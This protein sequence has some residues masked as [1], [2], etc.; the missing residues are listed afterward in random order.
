MLSE[1]TT[2]FAGAARSAGGTPSA[3][4]ALSSRAP[5]MC[6]RQSWRFAAAA[7][8]AVSSTESVVPPARVWVFSRMSRAARLSATTSSTAAGSM[9]P[10]AAQSGDGS[11][12]AISVI[13]IDSDERTC[14]AASS[15][16]FSP[17]AQNVSIATRFPIPSV[18]S[19]SAAGFPS[20]AATRSQSVLTDASSPTSAQ[21][22]SASR[23]ASHIASV[24]TEQTSERRSIMAELM[25]AAGGVPGRAPVCSPSS[26][27]TVPLTS[28]CSTPR[29]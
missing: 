13:P 29:A 21:P 19:Q 18:G 16:T 26:T 10:S 20:S 28:T 24:G 27:T 22:S 8:S 17:G 3:T 12:R 14:D 11:S 6:T 23:I 4:E 15:T 1:I 25:L 5:S 2:E 9:R 7:S